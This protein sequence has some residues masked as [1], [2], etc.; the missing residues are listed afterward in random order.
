MT[1]IERANTMI[2]LLNSTP[3]DQWPTA[4]SLDL[5]AAEARGEG[6]ERARTTLG[7]EDA[8]RL[9]IKECIEV[10]RDSEEVYDHIPAVNALKAMLHREG[11][12]AQ[13]EMFAKGRE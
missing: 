8:R 12:A 10:L 5:D 2:M 7:V 4:I 9:T 3:K 1:N 13:A 6:M 11:M